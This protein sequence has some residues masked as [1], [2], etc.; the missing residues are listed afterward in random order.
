M[1]WATSPEARAH[2]W[3]GGGAAGRGAGGGGPPPPPRGLLQFHQSRCNGGRRGVDSKYKHDW[4]NDTG[5]SP[6]AAQP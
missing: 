6:R 2:G 5:W 3:G 1:T 4:P